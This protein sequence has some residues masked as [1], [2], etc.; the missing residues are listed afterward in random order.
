M[1]G[2]NNTLSSSIRMYAQEAGLDDDVIANV[3]KQALR[4]AYKK[5]Y[6]T[7]ENLDFLVDDDG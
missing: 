2:D 3:V 1:A 7:D 4:T 5:Q 6:G